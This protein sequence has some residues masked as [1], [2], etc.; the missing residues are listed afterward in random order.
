MFHHPT[1]PIGPALN[2]AP[3]EEI[4]PRVV[5]PVPVTPVQPD[6]TKNPA[7]PP[8]DVAGKWKAIVK[9]DWG[10]TYDTIFEIEVDGSEITGIAGFLSLGRTIWDG[11]IAGNRISFMTKTQATMGCNQPNAEERHYYKGTVEGESIRFTM[12]TDSPAGE[13]IPIHFTA[14][15]VKAGPPRP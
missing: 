4:A 7:N 10:D 8:V 13:H 12:T 1:P 3:K 9:Y 11:K 6:G 5:P 15:K 14:H 2:P